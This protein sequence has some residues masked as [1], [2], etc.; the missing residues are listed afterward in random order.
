MI[1]LFASDLDGTLLNEKHEADDTIERTIQNIVD[2]G[3][4]FSVATGRSADMVQFSSVGDKIYYVCMNGAVI[5]DPQK[6]VIC[7]QTIDKQVLRELLERFPSSYLEYITTTH[8]FICQEKESFASFMEEKRKGLKSAETF[9]KRLRERIDNAMSFSQSMDMILQQD[10]CKINCQVKDEEEANALNAFL[11][12]HQDV[13][14]NAP[15]NHGGFEITKAGVNKGTAVLWLSQ[16]LG[17]AQ[18]EVAVYGDGG[19][20][21]EMLQMFAHSYAPSSA[22]EE[23]KETASMIIGPYQEYRVIRHMETLLKK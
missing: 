7:Q 10:I 21:L 9:L 2:S 13:L 15:S 8:T 19:N 3:R 17:I 12:S 1:R 22:Y 20:D 14:V 6:K 4:Y 18:E 23:A 16:K 5:M 11:D